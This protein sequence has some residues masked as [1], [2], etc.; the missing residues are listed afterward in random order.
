MT[1]VTFSL[2]PRCDKRWINALAVSR[3]VFVTGIFT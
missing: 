3:L 1:A 2:T